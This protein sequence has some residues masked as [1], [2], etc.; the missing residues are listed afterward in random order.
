MST[1]PTREIAK[2]QNYERRKAALERAIAS[3]LGGDSRHRTALATVQTA[4][5]FIALEK[6]VTDSATAPAAKWANRWRRP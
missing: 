1:D 5:R 4:D 2:L 6:L 3:R